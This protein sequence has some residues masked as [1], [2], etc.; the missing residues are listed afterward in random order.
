MA[1]HYERRTQY[2][3]TELD[4]EGLDEDP[5][6]QLDLWIA[7]ATLQEAPEP[8]A[9]SISTVTADGRPRSRIVLCRGV[10]ST[11]L[12]FFTN[13]DSD[14]GRELDATKVAAALFFWPTLER[15]V[16]IEGRIER[17]SVEVSAAYFQTRPRDSQIGAWASPQSQVL[18]DRESLLA[19]VA[20]MTERFADKEVPLP[21]HWGGYVLVPDQFEFWQGREN[22]LH[23]RFRYTL[24]SG[25]YERARL[26]P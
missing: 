6:K 19:R 17:T 8:L 22:R 7:E 23:D 4:L 14:K 1:H 24:T 20:E 25:R 5:V 2:Q 21:L 15:Q 26:A 12:R 16:R 13:Y 9:M 18:P 3:R 11:G 10:D